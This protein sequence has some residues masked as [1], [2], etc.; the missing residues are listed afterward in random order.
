MQAFKTNNIVR[1]TL[2]S[3]IMVIAMM[4]AFTMIQSDEVYAAKSKAPRL[5]AV[6]YYEVSSGTNASAEVIWYSSAGKS[7]SV[8]RKKPGGSWSKIATVKGKKSSTSYIDKN[9]G[10]GKNYIYTVRIG[11]GKYDP[12]GMQLIGT[13][14]VSVKT[15]NMSAKVSWT[16][17]SGATQYLVYRKADR[18]GASYRLIATVDGA[19]LSFTDYYYKT[20]NKSKSADKSILF[21]ANTFIDPSSNNLVYTVRAQKKTTY[22]KK[23]KYSLGLYQK[24]GDWQIEA[25]SIVS[26]DENGSEAKVTWGTVPNVDGYY[27]YTA[28]SENGFDFDNPDADVPSP[29]RFSYNK[30]VTAYANVDK[31]KYYCV[32]AYTKKRSGIVLS[33]H[34]LGEGYD[35]MTTKDRKYDED[36]LWFGDS[37]TYGSPYYRSRSIDEI[38][39]ITTS[40]EWHKFSISNRVNQLT[41]NQSTAKLVNETEKNKTHFYNPSCPGSTY[42]TP[43]AEVKS[44]T[45]YTYKPSYTNSKLVKLPYHASSTY[46]G[47]QDGDKSNFNRARMVDEIVKPVA[48]G[49]TPQRKTMLGTLD[50]TSTIEDYD[51]VVLSAG[52]NDYTDCAPLANTASHSYWYALEKNFTTYQTEDGQTASCSND[53]VYGVTDRNSPDYNP[54]FDKTTFY[55]AYNT[56]MKRIEDASKARVEAGKKPIKVVTVDLFYA[57]R[58]YFSTYNGRS[59]YPRM[60]RFKTKND[61][62]KVGGLGQSGNNLNDYQNCLNTLNKIWNDNSSYIKIYTYHTNDYGIVNSSNCPYNASDNLHFTKY[63]YGKFG[64]SIADFLMKNVFNDEYYAPKPSMFIIE[65]IID[66]IDNATDESS[67]DPSDESSNDDTNSS[68]ENNNDSGESTDNPQQDDVVLNPEDPLVP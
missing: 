58:V 54:S 19:N 21:D 6:S 51:I 20:V 65:D 32:R 12:N 22:K 3:F 46:E 27:V 23:A 17:V 15:N 68:S 28:S 40:P 2:C 61:T 59:Y 45:S 36:I 26:V 56:I 55:G 41:G 50:N 67:E 44:G 10:L 1:M 35:V 8:Y 60:N 57:D 52:T 38:T 39:G 66:E 24:E 53:V 37:I 13:T 47:W 9:I 14:K 64:D 4:V 30:N 7:Y 11:K 31:S 49:K 62:S 63:V 5:K 42:Y 43:I 25:P 34:N 48:E 33:K 29:G 18:T 16:K